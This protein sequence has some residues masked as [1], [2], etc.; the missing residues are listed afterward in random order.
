MNCSHCQKSLDPTPE[1]PFGFGW[2]L[3]GQKVLCTDCWLS[4]RQQRENANV[5]ANPNS[6]HLC[7]S[8]QKHFAT[9]GTKNP[10]FGIDRDPSLRGA[11][12]DVVLECGQHLRRAAENAW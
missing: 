3:C 10:V 7:D 8:C 6:K 12:A 4:R 11:A 1:R 9:C 2:Y 5:N